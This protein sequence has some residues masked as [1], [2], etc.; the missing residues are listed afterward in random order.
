MSNYTIRTEDF[1]KK[2]ITKYYVETAQDREIIDYIVSEH[3]LLLV[4]SRGVGKTMLLRVA[5]DKLDS[6]FEENKV[7]PVYLSFVKGILVNKEISND[8]FLYWMISKILSAFR[9][10]LQKKGIITPANNPFELLFGKD[11]SSFNALDEFIS[12]LENTWSTNTVITRKKMIEMLGISSGNSKFISEIDST[13]SIIELFCK[14]NG[15]RKVTFLFDEACHNFIPEQQRQFFTLFRDLR[16]PYICCKA[17][18]YPGIS[19]YGTLQRFHDVIEKR[20]ERNIFDKE[21]VEKMREIIEKQTNQSDYVKLASKGQELNALIYCSGGNPRLLLKSIDAVINSSKSFKRQDVNNVIREFYRTQI[22]DE[23]TRLSETYQ[24]HKELIDWSRRFI[25]NSVLPET[26]HKNKTR[27][28]KQSI[29]FA[30]HRDAPEKVKAAIHILEYTGIISIHTEGTRVRTEVFDRYQL[31]FGVVVANESTSSI[32]DKCFELFTGL[33]TKIYTD[34]NP[35]SP[36]FREVVDNPAIHGLTDTSNIAL[37]IIMRK[38]IND[39]MISKKIRYRL[40]EIG[41]HTIY[42]ILSKKEA[43]LRK[44]KQIGPVRSR[45]IYN[46]AYNAAIEYISG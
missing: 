15:I 1:K 12:V 30:L 9:T 26:I 24:G 42:D 4:G 43:F 37:D 20:V 6:L 33:S 32:V 19:Y 18:V 40:T 27:F 2:D 11:T 5:E 35:N 29:F 17:A 14:Q 3:Q 16:S 22:W 21:Y 28:P 38:S 34:Y 10:A 36:V 31:N 25:E 44:A 46:A 41:I 45:E 13:K 7:L 39:L 23:H 8:H